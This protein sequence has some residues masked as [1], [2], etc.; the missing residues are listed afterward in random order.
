M[1]P[2]II[3]TYIC[4]VKQSRIFDNLQWEKKIILIKYQKKNMKTKYNGVPQGSLMGVTLFYIYNI[5]TFISSFYIIVKL[6]C[7]NSKKKKE[8]AYYIL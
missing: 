5:I 3:L 2:R 7:W 6:I 1:L 8:E 4:P